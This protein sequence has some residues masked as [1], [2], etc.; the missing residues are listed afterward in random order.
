MRN[1]PETILVPIDFNEQSM[2]ALHRS[3][4]FARLLGTFSLTY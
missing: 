3:Y 4:D 2:Y 1:L